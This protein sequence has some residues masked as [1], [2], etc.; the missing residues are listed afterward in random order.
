M[1]IAAA[2]ITNFKRVRD[3]E[4]VPTADRSIILIGGKNA[5]GKSSV[6]D[7]LTV[8]FGGKRA[9]PSDPVR[10]GADQAEVLVELEDG[11]TIRRRIQVDGTSTLEVRDKEGAIKSPQTMLDRLVGA[12][13]LDPLAFLALPAKEQRAQLMKL[14]PGAERIDELNVKRERAFARRTEIGRDLTKAE[15]ELARLP[16]TD[17]ELAAI[18]IADARAELARLATEERDADQRAAAR[19]RAMGVVDACQDKVRTIEQRIAELERQLEAERKALAEASTRREQALE[20]AS[21]A[22]E[23]AD[24]AMSRWRELKPRRAELDEQ[25]AQA[26][27]HNRK[28]YELDA[29]RKRRAEAEAEVAKLTEDRDELTDRIAKID[30]RK[31]EILGAAQLPVEGLKVADDGI[32]LGGVPFAQASGA[33]RLRVAL[34]LAIAAAPQL[35]DVWIRDGALLDEDHLALVAKQAAAAGKRVWIER[36]GTADPGV[37]VIQD[38]QV[39]S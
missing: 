1:K 39:V 28:V 14:I 23:Q 6:L 34:A 3:V 19:E 8:A 27:Q 10:H 29:Q 26:D 30:H 5:Q 7:A 11:I 32:E 37:I 18:D 17:V 13:F 31:A 20:V 22:S 16:A 2:K 24:K 9:Q 4:I 33:E 36:V 35:H 38:G 15:G 25:L 21:A 12:R